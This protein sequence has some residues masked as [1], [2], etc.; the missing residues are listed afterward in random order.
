MTSPFAE[1]R[2]DGLAVH[3][4][5]DLPK[6]TH[7]VPQPYRLPADVDLDRYRAFLDGHP[8]L[9]RIGEARHI[10]CEDWSWVRAT[11]PSPLNVFLR[12]YKVVS[13]RTAWVLTVELPHVADY[14]TLIDI[15][16][17]LY[18][19]SGYTTSRGGGACIMSS[20]APLHAHVADSAACPT[21][22]FPVATH[23]FVTL[24]SDYPR[25]DDD[26][27]HRIVYRHDVPTDVK[28]ES[29]RFP[30][31][32]NRREATQ[33][34]V[35]PYVTILRGQ[36]G[37]IEFVCL[38]SIVA[39][40]AAVVDLQMLRQD[41]DKRIGRLQDMKAVN[42]GDRKDA[43]SVVSELDAADVELAFLELN[44]STWVEAQTDWGAV[45]PSLRQRDFHLS[46]CAA[47]SVEE[48][49]KR[50][51]RLHARLRGAIASQRELT[52]STE[53]EA[54]RVRRERITLVLSTVTLIALPVT[55]S[56]TFLGANIA[57]VEPERSLRDGYGWVYLTSVGILAVAAVI[58]LSVAWFRE[59]RLSRQLTQ[60]DHTLMTL[61]R[62]A[63][64]VDNPKT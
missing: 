34:V 6:T 28:S 33:G 11:A 53:L 24:G 51:S 44:L 27:A 26:W 38:F 4:V 56:L 63:V 3:C 57:E 55:I 13:G 21:A 37:Y 50:Q 43:Q 64:G 41:A 12:P 20:G 29:I 60:L 61:R 8:S 9:P 7:E 22:R 47:L 46:L 5:I 14:S 36:Q 17:D 42:S 25:I 62:K 49:A 54:S 2:E 35:S 45:L 59:R 40:T 23:L 30:C 1:H 39:L 58:A 19:W 18:Y 52:R 31:E 15:L 10:P 16:E 48:N 32:L